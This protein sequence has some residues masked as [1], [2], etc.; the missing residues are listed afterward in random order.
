M[1]RIRGVPSS[2][3]LFHINYTPTPLPLPHTPLSL[4]P[5]QN[6]KR[7]KRGENPLA[8]KIYHMVLVWS[9]IDAFLLCITVS[10]LLF[11]K[12]SIQQNTYPS[13]IFSLDTCICKLTN[14]TH[15]YKYIC[16]YTFWYTCACFLWSFSP[17]VKPRSVLVASHGGA[18]DEVV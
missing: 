12:R 17:N 11:L 4:H 15:V 1:I 10:I 9:T 2:V 13:I 16:I 3:S 7:K 8:P 5:I 18:C 6:K 14:S